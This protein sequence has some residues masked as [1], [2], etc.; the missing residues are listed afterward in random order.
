MSLILYYCHACGNLLR[1]SECELALSL[2]ESINTA[3]CASC[4]TAGRRLKKSAET[5]SPEKKPSG[6][7]PVLTKVAT[8]ENELPHRNQLIARIA[9]KRTTGTSAP[10]T[11]TILLSKR[12]VL[13]LSTVSG[14]FLL[15]ICV[16]MLTPP[17]KNLSSTILA[18]SISPMLETESPESESGKTAK[19]YVAESIPVP[20]SP[21]AQL[22]LSNTPPKR[23]EKKVES[24]KALLPYK[25]IPAAT[26]LTAAPSGFLVIFGEQSHAKITIDRG[27]GSVSTQV[28][29]GPQLVSPKLVVFNGNGAFGSIGDRSLVLEYTSD[30]ESNVQIGLEFEGGLW[31]SEMVKLK[32]SPAGLLRITPGS[33]KKFLR[34][35]REERYE[36]EL[37]QIKFDPR[38]DI[39]GNLIVHRVS[40]QEVR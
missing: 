8:A 35:S 9:T 2:G 26:N 28:G 5:L 22:E 30:S 16:A 4:A 15:L 36:K 17:S 7:K 38:D 33:D 1:N 13:L 11:L 34:L 21:P 31:R 3:C 37:K 19:I 18:A 25:S 20:L 6:G 14:V 12:S 24:P 39:V 10:P 29:K 23:V 27:S 32:P 40:L